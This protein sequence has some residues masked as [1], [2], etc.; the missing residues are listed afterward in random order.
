MFKVFG[1]NDTLKLVAVLYE[2]A[3]TFLGP[4]NDV[5]VDGVFYYLKKLDEKV[6][7]LE[8]RLFLIVDKH[9]LLWEYYNI[10]KDDHNFVF[11]KVD[12]PD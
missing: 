8:N 1:N 4:C 12:R 7:H 3:I 2:E 11:N 10:D 5:V 6:I 9:F